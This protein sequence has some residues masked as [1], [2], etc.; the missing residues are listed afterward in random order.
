MKYIVA[1][2]I[3]EQFP[4]F[5]AG[6]VIAR[7][8]KHI[9][10]PEEIKEKFRE[11]EKNLKKEFAEFDA[12]SRHPNIQG[13][14]DAYKA[15]GADPGRYAPSNE[16]LA[17]QVLKGRNFWGIHPIVDIYNYISIKYI[18]P[19]GGEDMDA[20]EKGLILD[21]AE[22]DEEFIKLGG[23]EN[24]PP[25]PG[26]IIY[27]DDRGVVCRRWNWREGDRTKITEDTKNAIIVIDALPP[28]TDAELQKVTDELAK[29]V[30]RYCGAK[31]ETYFVSR[32]N[33]EAEF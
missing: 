28:T 5:K 6:I 27:R 20:L 7:D 33:P 22:G 9:E 21:F 12:P 31:T 8:I 25:E 24:D 11:A 26:E 18:L 23:E 4:E 14:R 29:L 1:Q 15:F 13:W 16:A 10:L 19:I 30:S 3:F 32:N 2:E 17:R